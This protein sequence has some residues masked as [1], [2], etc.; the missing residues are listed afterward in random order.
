MSIIVI[1]IAT[2]KAQVCQYS[3]KKWIK[4][5]RPIFDKDATNKT[6]TF[7]ESFNSQSNEKS[8]DATS[9]TNESSNQYSLA[10]LN[11]NNVASTDVIT[12]YEDSYENLD[13]NENDDTD[14]DEYEETKR[15]KS[16]KR[17]FVQI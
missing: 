8:M 15:R 6:Q 12:W 10:N 11:N 17:V 7:N 1:L 2:N 3:V 14:F 4:S 16:S 9:N 5:R 13:I